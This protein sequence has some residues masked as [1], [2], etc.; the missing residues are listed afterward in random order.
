AVYYIM[1][2][3][4]ILPDSLDA[5]GYADFENKYED[6]LELLRYFRSDAMANIGDDLKAFIPQEEFI[7]LCEEILFNC[8]LDAVK[9]VHDEYLRRIG[10]LRKRQFLA[11]FLAQHPGIQH[12][13]AAPP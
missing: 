10:E 1:K 5:L 11:S 8:K 13:A 2:L 3:S 6:L 4:Q 12:K 7:D 9:A